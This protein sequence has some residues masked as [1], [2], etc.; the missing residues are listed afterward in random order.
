MKT[1]YTSNYARN[2]QHPKAVSI[3]AYLP[4]WGYSG[5]WYRPLA[6]SFENLHDILDG[7]T[8]AEEYNERYLKE[9]NES[10]TVEQV[11][12]DLPDGSVLLCFEKPTDHCHR[13]VVRDW[14]NASGLCTVEE[15][16]SEKEKIA[17]GIPIVGSLED[18]VI[19]ED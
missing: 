4:K 15:I 1:F 19:F 5:L 17:M 9:L 8:T 3:S 16:L 6:P 18:L 2:G 13:H 12:N 11:V 7:K 10:T 14:L